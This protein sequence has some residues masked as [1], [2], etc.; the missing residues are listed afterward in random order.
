MPPEPN[1]LALGKLMAEIDRK[2]QELEATESN[3]KK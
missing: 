2:M 1:S 3:T